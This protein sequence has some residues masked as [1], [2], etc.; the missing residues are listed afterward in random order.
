[1]LPPLTAPALLQA[2][3]ALRPL[4]PATTFP[5]RYATAPDL[6]P[7][8]EAYDAFFFDAFGVLNIGETAIAGA[9][10]RITALRRA[11]RRVTVVSN[12]ASVPVAALAR[13]YAALGFDFAV[14]EIV[15]SREALRQ[16][17]HTLPLQTWGVMAPADADLSDLP[18]HMLPLAPGA[19]RQGDAFERADG[20]IL[21]AAEG[22]SDAQQQR[23]A[24][25]LRARPRPVLVGNPDLAA[26]R[27]HGFSVEPGYCGMA[28]LQ[29]GLCQPLGFGKPYRSVFD[30]ALQRLGPAVARERVLMVGDTLHTDILGGRH[31]GL[32]TALVTGQGVSAALDWDDAIRSTGIVPHHVI[33]RI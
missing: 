14:E 27:E 26:P 13:K 8:T 33:E 5:P 21:L 31:A 15:S 30:L 20:F 3:E 19:P 7:L 16:H 29:A 12:A 22:W 18:G 11:G 6:A 1:M 4:L 2:Y 32:H 10:E 9:A 17:L 25:A 24:A 28:L 23:L